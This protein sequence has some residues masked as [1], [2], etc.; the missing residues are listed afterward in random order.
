MPRTPSSCAQRLDRSEESGVG[1]WPVHGVAPRC[2]P[3]SKASSRPSVGA[4]RADAFA[5][6][7][8]RVRSNRRDM[9]WTLITIRVVSFLVFA[10]GFL[11]LRSPSG[12]SSVEV[13]RHGLTLG[14]QVEVALLT[15]CS[16][17]LE[18]PYSAASIAMPA[19]LLT[20]ARPWRANVAV[21]AA[22][23][24]IG[25]SAVLC[26][27]LVSTPVR[28]QLE[29]ARLVFRMISDGVLTALV[30][31]VCVLSTHRYWQLRREHFAAK[32]IGRYQLRRLLGRG[33]MGEVW[34]AWH[35]TLRREVAVK[36]L[37]GDPDQA[38][39]LRFEREV[40]A[41]TELA[42][43]N[44]I[45]VF[46]YG[47][48]DDGTLFYTM[49]ILTGRTLAD[50]VAERGP[51]PIGQAIHLARQ[52]ASALAEAHNKGIVHRDVK[53]EN[54]FV[55]TIGGV[56]DFIKVLDFGIA[57]GHELVD[58]TMTARVV[59]S[60]T[61]I[62]PEAAAGRTVVPASDVYS[63][64]V[65]LYY[66]LTG[67]YPFSGNLAKLLFAHLNQ[68]AAEVHSRRPEVPEDLSA[69]V[70]KCLR[71]DPGDRYP[72]AV[73]LEAALASCAERWPWT[74]TKEPRVSRVRR[75]FDEEA[76]TVETAPPG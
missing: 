73:A 13:M 18:S 30:T 65:S 35:P 68:E 9:P 52:T 64:G 44:T 10:A 61:T 16:G 1:V 26:A 15:V 75:M 20:C 24:L 53:P 5:L 39:R 67:E 42:H 46:D 37:T 60:P 48:S 43:P 32:E 41:T 54:L 2:W 6:A 25:P 29:S 23:P 14:L 66:M 71:K 50:L 57:K 3:A 38:M 27:A 33:G 59:G 74:P 22:L 56:S 72:D 31:L 58:V 4:G 49:E 63:L 8:R 76:P 45:R 47:T 7:R 12:A 28:S 62:S 11:V 51:L 36:L 40:R 69:I 19:A 55:A 34:A 21:G 17:A 70:S